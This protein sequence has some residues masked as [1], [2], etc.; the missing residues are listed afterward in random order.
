MFSMMRTA[1]HGKPKTKT[2]TDIEKW[3]QDYVDKKTTECPFCGGENFEHICRSC[4]SD[5]EK[6]TC[7]KYGKYCQKCFFHIFG[8]ISEIDEEKTKLG[9]K[10]KCDDPQCS[11]CLLVNCQ[12]ENCPVHTMERKATRRNR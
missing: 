11:K 4:Y 10:C 6:D 1:R 5:I 2:M 7:W 3:K 9:V 8:D 12:D